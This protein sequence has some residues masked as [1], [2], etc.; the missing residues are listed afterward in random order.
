MEPKPS[1]DLVASARRRHAGLHEEITTDKQPATLLTECISDWSGQ[2]PTQL[3]ADD[4]ERGRAHLPQALLAKWA[5]VIA[6]L[7]FPIGL[8]ALFVKD[9]AT[10]TATFTPSDSGTVMLVSGKGPKAVAEAFAVMEV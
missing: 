3:R 2:A 1:D 10:I 7:F 6:I 8:A 4:P 5:V 9:D